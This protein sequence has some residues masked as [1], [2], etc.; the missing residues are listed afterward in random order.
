MRV[1]QSQDT[2]WGGIVVSDGEDRFKGLTVAPGATA[3]TLTL[4]GNQVKAQ[5]LTVEAD[6]KVNLTGTW[7][8]ATTVAGT[9]G[10]MGTLTGNL[11]LTDGATI[12]VNDIS[13][14]L[15]VSGS[16]TATGAITIELPEGV[17]RGKVIAT[18]SKPDITGATFT[19]KVG[20]VEK[21]LK[22]TATDIG[23]KVAIPGTKIIIR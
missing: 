15:E 14:P 23:L 11:T 8:G 4:S 20:G 1:V 13:D 3:G 16:L 5:T 17:E 22:V 6:A 2:E 9:F 21:K 10:G 19:V 18:G 7:V 12:K